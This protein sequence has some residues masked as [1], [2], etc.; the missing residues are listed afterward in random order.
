MKLKAAAVECKLPSMDRPAQ[1]DAK[2]AAIVAI[3]RAA[4]Y[5]TAEAGEC[6]VVVF[7]ESLERA[8]GSIECLPCGTIICDDMSRVCGR[9]SRLTPFNIPFRVFVSRPDVRWVVVP[10]SRHYYCCGF[11]LCILPSITT[12][13]P[14]CIVDMTLLRSTAA[15]GVAL[16]GHRAFE[17]MPA[18]VM[19]HVGGHM[20]SIY[21]DSLTEFGR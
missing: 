6:R 10:P 4:G 14:G 17:P 19:R 9:A 13:C 21:A 16:L 5:Q 20:A 8:L 15:K 2:L 18:D 12:E 1:R 11:C 7:P 3:V